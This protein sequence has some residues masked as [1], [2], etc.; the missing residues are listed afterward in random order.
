MTPIGIALLAIVFLSRVL[1]S[2]EVLPHLAAGL[3]VRDTHPRE[4]TVTVTLVRSLTNTTVRIKTAKNPQFLVPL[5]QAL[6]RDDCELSFTGLAANEKSLSLS[7][8][9]DY[10][11][12]THH[13]NQSYRSP[14]PVLQHMREFLLA[15]YGYETRRVEYSLSTGTQFWYGSYETLDTALGV[16]FQNRRRGRKTGSRQVHTAFVEQQAPWGLDRIDMHYGMLDGAYNY[17]NMASSVD[18]YIIDTGIRVTHQEFGGRAVFLANTVGDG[19]N[20]DC[21]GHGTMV[22]SLA[23]GATYGVAKGVNLWAVKVLDCAGNGDTF[24]IATGAMAVSENAAS[25][26]TQG[27]KAVASLSLGGDASSIIDDALLQLIDDGI[28]VVVAAG[29]EY[30]D[31]C[32]YSPAR[33]GGNSLAISVGASNIQDAKPGFSNYGRCVTISAPG[34]NITGAS[35]NN[36]AATVALSGTSMATPFV[37]GV[38]ALVLD[39]NPLLNVADVYSLITA[40]ATPDVITG[41][42]VQGGGQNLLYSLIQW[43]APPD[44]PNT[45]PTPSP[46]PSPPVFS[47]PPPSPQPPNQA[48]PGA[49]TK[50]TV[51]LLSVLLLLVATLLN[52]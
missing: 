13:T 52:A 47:P 23:G 12:N 35:A 22:A 3:G 14:L 4:N 6:R 31:A 44:I 24:T 21:N 16:Y 38:A 11:N 1:Y 40:W 49:S 37:A 48:I 7:V 51:S 30:G 32:S 19:I 46:S 27:F 25:R 15:T 29:N 36:N 5:K 50:L 43:N 28:T 8:Y 2:V 9:C 33:L 20:T 10:L 39:Q 41:A 45:Q 17:M 26:A 34:V 42:T 18:V